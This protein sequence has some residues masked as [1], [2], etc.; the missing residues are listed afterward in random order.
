MFISTK[1]VWLKEDSVFQA[2][3]YT[4]KKKKNSLAIW[5]HVTLTSL[6]LNKMKNI[7]SV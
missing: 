2:L 4:Q 5:V 3:V 7:S 6:H 1:L